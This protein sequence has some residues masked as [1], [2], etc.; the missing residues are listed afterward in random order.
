MA[1]ITG[2][3]PLNL[4]L[5]ATL[6]SYL[7]R[8]AGD[9]TLRRFLPPAVFWLYVLPIVAAGILGSRHVGQIPLGVFSEEQITFTN[10]NGYL[11]DVL[12]KPLLL[13]VFAMLVA[14]A[15][16]RSREAEKFLVPTLVSIG[17]MATIVV[18]FVLA[19]MLTS[20]QSLGY[21][22]GARSR[23]FLSQ[24]GLHANDLGRL[25]AV[26][27]AL[28]LFTWA[29]THDRALKIALAVAMLAV[30]GALVLTFSRGAFF[31][32]VVVNVIFLVTRRRAYGFLL[33]M[34]LIGAMMLALP[35]TLYDRMTV[36]FHGDLN[37]VSA[38]RIDTIWLPLVPE[39]A[40][41]PFL[42]NGLSSILWSDAMRAGEILTVSHAHNAYLQTL[43]DMG[44]IGF[45]L[46]AAFFA[47]L[48]RDFRRLGR[49]ARLS[50]TLRGFFTGAAAGLASFL[51]AGV[52]G[53]QLVPC[54][55]QA[56]LWVAV[57]ML[58]GVR[59][60]LAARAPA[61]APRARGAAHAA[62]SA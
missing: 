2:L 22:A 62:R 25:F 28:A 40:R 35:G 46:L 44:L 20:G 6:A 11:R 38:G 51:A 13:V 9:G 17:L 49:E 45:A 59:A 60:K 12:V 23:A 16:K 15:V 52:A 19:F 53:S 14:A 8:A 61:P 54:P 31:A 50:P 42:G 34:L 56:F 24:L 4:L 33:G 43:L 27:Y 10:A 58:Y 1:G 32:F 29:V 3:N 36:G 18:V 37:A 39:L 55:E 48:M 7:L 26:G 57:G 21:L 47:L 30:I 41:S 5:A